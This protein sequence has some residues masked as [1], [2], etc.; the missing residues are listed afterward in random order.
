MRMKDL[1]INWDQVQDQISKVRDNLGEFLNKEET[2]SFLKQVS[3][4]DFINQDY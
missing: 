3:F 1:D 2:Q 4:Y